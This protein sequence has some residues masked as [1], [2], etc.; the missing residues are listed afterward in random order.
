VAATDV[1]NSL[2]ATALIVGSQTQY[3]G[4]GISQEITAA[5]MTLYAGYH[6]GS[7]EVILQ[8]QSPTATNQRAKS[9]P[10]DDFQ[11]FYTGATLRF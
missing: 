4:G 6:V 1:I 3:W 10:I 9:N 7:T 5:S 2:G 8:N 11:M